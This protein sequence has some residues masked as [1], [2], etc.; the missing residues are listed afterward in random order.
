MQGMEESVR[1]AYRNLSTPLD[2][3]N[4]HLRGGHIIPWQYPANT[5]VYSRRNDMGVIVA[6]SDTYEASGSLFWDDGETFG[7]PL[8]LKKKNITQR[9]ETTSSL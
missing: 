7:L 6:L 1:G 3:I 9:N 4:L 8:I 2:A 5:T